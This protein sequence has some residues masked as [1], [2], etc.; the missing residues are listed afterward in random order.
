MRNLYR[1]TAGMLAATASAFA[2][3]EVASVASNGFEVRE[4]AHVAAPP[5]KVY[6][7][8][9]HPA[10]W[11]SSD[12]TFSGSSVNLTLDARPGGC[13]CETLRDGPW[14]ALVLERPRRLD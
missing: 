2:A 13:W 14:S 7:G 8:L 1:I 12:H 4:S 11:W 3:A 6:A 9:L 10:R 5:D